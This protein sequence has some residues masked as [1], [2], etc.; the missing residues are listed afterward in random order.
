M[1]AEAVKTREKEG[2]RRLKQIVRVTLRPSR[3][4]HC[5]AERS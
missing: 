1:S 3:T 4:I 2:A 5:K